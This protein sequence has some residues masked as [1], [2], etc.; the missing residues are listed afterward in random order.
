MA[1]FDKKL[2]ELSKN[3]EVPL[4]YQKRVEET[5]NHLP[6]REE[7]QIHKRHLPGKYMVRLAIC[8]VFLVALFSV[9]VTR[10]D[11]NIFTIF[12]QTIMDFFHIEQGVSPEELGVGSKKEHKGSKA[13]LFLE[14]QETVVDSHS[15]YLLVKITASS[16]VDFGE[17]I[18]FDYLAFC[19]GGNY[20]T[21]T[22]IGG[23]TSCS[24]LERSE[25]KANEAIYVVSLSSNEQ[26]QDGSQVTAFF[27]DF[28]ID[29]YGDSREMLVE[30]MW[31]LSFS[32][33]YT[34]TE[35][36]S[37]EGTAD[38]TYPFLGKQAI[39]N[40]IEITPL[41]MVMKSDVS[42]VPYD[43]LGIS[44]TSLRVVLKMLD[45]REI[46]LMSHDLEEEVMVSSSS[47]SYESIEEK[48]Y[49][50]NKFEFES[51]VNTG[52]IQGVYIEDLYV[53][54]KEIELE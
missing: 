8:I 42:A 37:I 54:V 28:M 30:G 6:A 14:L 13:D 38:M 41:G 32:A 43:A 29:P 52:Q 4:E 33:D 10:A 21:D 46:L 40:S 44:D 5:L 1:K 23:A 22:L 19:N 36:I 25:E 9:N 24:L 34:V 20:N 51:M 47:I 17:N 12:K 31:S 15:I 7:H 3:M 53:P 27:K 50:S 2:K 16:N 26:I 11:A 48:T 49:Q 35:E 45:G 18:T 39:L